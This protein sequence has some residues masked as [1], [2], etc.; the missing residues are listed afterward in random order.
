MDLLDDFV[1]L[2]D[3]V[4]QHSVQSDPRLYLE[5]LRA[6]VDHA[7]DFGDQLFLCL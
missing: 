1:V 6:L 3:D 7:Q 4:S 2:N 5:L